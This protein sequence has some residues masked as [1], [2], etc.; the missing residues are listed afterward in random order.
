M[1]QEGV[2]WCR[3]KTGLV[4]F[5][6][7]DV[8]KPTL[9]RR[10]AMW[11][12]MQ[13][14]TGREEELVLMIRRIVP[15]SAYN[16]CFVAYYERMWRKEHQSI[17]HVERL[18]PGYVFIITEDPE[19][20]FLSLK[21]VPAMSKLMADEGY[22]FLALDSEEERFYKDMI[23]QDHVMH[24]SYIKT[25]GRGRI[26][27]MSEPL[28]KYISQIIRY[29]FKKRFV[30]LQLTLL[31]QKKTV[32]LGILLDEDIRQEIAF[33]KVEAPLHIPETYEIADKTEKEL[34]SRPLAVGDHVKVISGTF[35]NMSGVIWKLKKNTVEIGVHLFDQDMS[36][37]VPLKN[38]AFTSG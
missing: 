4:Y 10:R 24:L 35:E 3:Q 8:A 22:T 30:I 25:D 36:M 37:E 33:G 7:A 34:Q 1:N 18:F 26:L 9:K 29:Q 23:A 12:V 32:P 11:Y 27:Q 16:D 38:I 31:G 2:I 15:T 19:Q 17:I 13:T 5:C 14:L 6:T 21:Q 20:L 28:N